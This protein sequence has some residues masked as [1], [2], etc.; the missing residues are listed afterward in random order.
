MPEI[1]MSGLKTRKEAADRLRV[2]DKTIY[3]MQRKG[4]LTAVILS[5]RCVRYLDVE[6]EE[7]VGKAMSR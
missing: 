7:L 2:S 4:L 6:I 3:R 5:Q 1:P